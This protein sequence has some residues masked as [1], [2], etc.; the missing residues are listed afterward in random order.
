MFFVLWLDLECVS[1]VVL[2]FEAQKIIVG[3]YEIE[4]SPIVEI[5]KIKR[6]KPGMIDR[7]YSI[8]CWWKKVQQ[9][10]RFIT[11]DDRVYIVSLPTLAE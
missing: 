7:F 5:E 11:E 3:R 8:V 6:F 2:L 10:Y 4:T 1:K 9:S